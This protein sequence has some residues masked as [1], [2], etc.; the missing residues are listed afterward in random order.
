MDTLLEWYFA[1]LRGEF[2][3]Y[4]V[5]YAQK[6]LSDSIFVTSKYIS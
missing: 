4:I 5:I 6:L 3:T 1:C 2:T